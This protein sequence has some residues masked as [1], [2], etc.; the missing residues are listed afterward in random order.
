MNQAGKESNLRV[1]LKYRDK[2]NQ[3][4]FIIPVLQNLGG[5]THNTPSNNNITI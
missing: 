4:Y 1:F 2:S 3:P 5:C